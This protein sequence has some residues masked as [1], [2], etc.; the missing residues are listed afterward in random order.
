MSTRTEY[1]WDKPDTLYAPCARKFPRIY[2]QAW[3]CLSPACPAFWRALPD[4]LTYNPAFLSIIDAR[5][6]PLAYR[7][8]LR[9]APG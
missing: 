5:P 7:D 3:A 9:P 6:L 1:N 4:E 8:A 2:Q